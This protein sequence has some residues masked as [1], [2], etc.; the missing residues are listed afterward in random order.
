MEAMS[1]ESAIAPA[2]NAT[3]KP[4]VPSVQARPKTERQGLYWVRAKQ[5]G[6]RVV[7]RPPGRNLP[8]VQ[9]PAE[10]RGV[11]AKS[12]GYNKGIRHKMHLTEAP[13]HWRHRHCLIGELH[14]PILEVLP[15]ICMSDVQRP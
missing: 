12:P 3:L 1:R 5:L 15:R 2:G 7:R 10:E 11:P 6:D 8:T 4:G 13:E 14:I 9:S